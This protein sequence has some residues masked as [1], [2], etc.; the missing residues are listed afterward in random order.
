MKSTMPTVSSVRPARSK[1]ARSS[2]LVPAVFAAAL[3]PCF[4]QAQTAGCNLPS[5]TTIFG[6]T[7]DNRIL[8]YVTT[9]ENASGPLS[10]IGSIITRNADGT[11]A[12]KS[13]IGID[14]RPAD[15]NPGALYT[16]TD[17]GD[18]RVFDAFP[19]AVNTQLLTAP[20]SNLGVPF[21]GGLH[22]TMDF[23][24]V[25]DAIRLVGSND[26][27]FAIINASG[28]NLNA[29]AQ[30][31]ALRYATGDVA[32]GVDPHIT[33]GA[34]D[35]NFVGATRTTFYM[36]DYARDTLVTIAD[37]S[38][39]GSSNTG[40]GML[41]TI[42]QLLEPNGTP[43]AL[44]P[45]SGLD[46]VTTA[47]GRNVAVGHTSK[48][49][50]CVDLATVNADLSLGTT[51]NVTVF[52]LRK[53]PFVANGFNSLGFDDR[54]IDIAVPIR[55]PV[56]ADAAVTVVRKGSTSTQARLGDKVSFTVTVRN[57]GPSIASGLS[58]MVGA[59]QS[60]STAN[61]EIVGTF[62]AGGASCSRSPVF[63]SIGQVSCQLPALKSGVQLT[64]SFDAQT[65]RPATAPSAPVTLNASVRT[66]GLVPDPNTANNAANQV[67]A[68]TF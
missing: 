18:V 26:Q 61:L 13:V 59:A 35:N 43:I 19:G 3:C 1:P 21:Q 55:A 16:V 40:G 36:L 63:G 64:M 50:F 38:A 29:F 17:G 8:E 10:S 34:Y 31:T 49:L 42:G 52:P 60:D 48:R 66:S 22:S 37:R 5:G 57:N 14:F 46:I 68:L 2:L 53:N 56:S 30:Q 51:Q 62:V 23:N 7:V 25:L 67:I 58:V 45:G 28:G 27:N 39:T 12:D 15:A 6:L 65:I 20:V 32:A 47:D 4:A 11:I 41:K 33:T 9:N 44:T 54:L 24:P